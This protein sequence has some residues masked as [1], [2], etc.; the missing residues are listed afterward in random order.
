LFW[1]RGVV[2]E[3]RPRD[4]PYDLTI[5]TSLWAVTAAVGETVVPTTR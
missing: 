5:S 1:T 3:E 4:D 2:G